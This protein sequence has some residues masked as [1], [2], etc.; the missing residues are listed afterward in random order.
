MTLALFVF[1]NISRCIIC[2]C[3]F[4]PLIH[5]FSKLLYQLHVPVLQLCIH[6]VV[7]ILSRSCLLAPCSLL[8]YSSVDQFSCISDHRCIFCHPP[9]LI[10]SCLLAL[11]LCCHTVILVSSLLCIFSHTVAPYSCLLIA[12]YS[13]C[14]VGRFALLPYIPQLICCPTEP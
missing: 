10:S 8:C 9:A 13:L 2:F 12:L 4:V 3:F 7:L 1:P 6:S 11:C 5:V 14:R